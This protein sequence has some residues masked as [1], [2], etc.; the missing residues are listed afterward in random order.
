[1]G[2][3]RTILWHFVGVFLITH[4]INTHFQI[5]FQDWSS[6]LAAE[7]Q[8]AAEKCEIVRERGVNIFYNTTRLPLGSAGQML[9]P[10]IDSREQAQQ[11]R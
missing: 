7:A 5:L 6:S 11:V 8:E 10:W 9:Q 4:T 3:K 1:M 2:K